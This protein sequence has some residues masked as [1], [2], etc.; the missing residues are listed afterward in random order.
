MPDR[1]HEGSSEPLIRLVP[2]SEKIKDEVEL[3]VDMVGLALR[4]ELDAAAR[5][6]RKISPAWKMKAAGQ[7]LPEDTE[8]RTDPSAGPWPSQERNAVRPVHTVVTKL[9]DQPHNG[10]V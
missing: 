6:Q 10:A 1:K 7:D 8:R 5:L 3:D 4:V 9:A 2:T